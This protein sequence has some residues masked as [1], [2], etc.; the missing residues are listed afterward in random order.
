MALD[1]YSRVV[2]KFVNAQPNPGEVRREL[3]DFYNSA[4][5][6]RGI[7][8]GDRFVI[9]ERGPLSGGTII[10]NTSNLVWIY[11]K[12]IMLNQNIAFR[13]RAKKDFLTEGSFSCNS[14]DDSQEI[15]NYLFQKLPTVAFGY[16][17]ELRSLEFSR[18][19]DKFERFREY[20]L[21]QHGISP[22]AP[23]PRPQPAPAPAPVRPNPAPVQPNPIPVRPAPAPAN[24]G[25][26]VTVILQD[27]GTSTINVMRALRALI[28]E[29][30]VQEAFEMVKATPLTLRTGI[31]RAE[32]EQ[33]AAPFRDAGAT[34]II[35]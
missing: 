22:N 17:D 1:F 18:G 35:Q 33:I 8:A 7:R 28:P 27:A 32:A 23:T 6:F 13:V 16:T 11:R 30:S 9:V 20:A 34:I 4:E 31:P 25:G 29:M 15:L 3:I 21:K 5:E 19:L 2:D 26:K 24:A 12:V 14:I 10:L